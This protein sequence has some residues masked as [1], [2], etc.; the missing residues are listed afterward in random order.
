MFVFSTYLL[1]FLLQ[2]RSGELVGCI[3]WFHIQHVPIRHTFDGPRYAKNKKYLK[4]RD[5]DII[6][7]FFQVFLVFG[8]ASHVKSMQCGYSLDAELNPPKIWVRTQGDISKIWTKKVVLFY[9]KYVN[10]T[11]MVDSFYWNSIGSWI[12]THKIYCWRVFL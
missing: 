6:I 11:I 1:V 2:F 4:K 8:V 12:P 7:T 10:S 5:D 3:I 9:D